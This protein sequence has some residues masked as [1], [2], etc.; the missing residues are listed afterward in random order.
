MPGI[1]IDGLEISRSASLN[2]R[3]S[4]WL[5][6]FQG[7]CACRL[8]AQSGQFDCAGECPLSDKSGQRWILARAGLSAYDPSAPLAVYRNS[9]LGWLGRMRDG[10]LEKRTSARNAP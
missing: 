6:S 3:L 5:L 10:R 8:F 7:K 2:C 9:V 4:W 1:A